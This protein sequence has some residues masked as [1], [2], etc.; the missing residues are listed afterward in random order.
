MSPRLQKLIDRIRAGEIL[1]ADGAWGTQMQKLGLQS[2]DCPEEWNVTH[3]DRLKKIAQDYYH[4]GADFCLT[5][6]FGGTRYR[7]MRHGFADKVDEFN[8]AGFLIVKDVADALDRSVCASVGPTGE[9][10]EPEGMLSRK[11]MRDAFREQMSALKNAGAEW[12]CIETMYVVPEAVEA[13]KAAVELGLYCA[14]CMTFD[15]DGRGG[16]QT[17]FGTGVEEAIHAVDTAGADIVGT[18]CGNGIADMVRIARLIRPATR[19][20]LMVKSNA[21]LPRQVDGHFVY[22]ET[23]G[24]M[25]QKISELRDIGVAIVGGCCGTTPAHIT[26]FRAALDAFKK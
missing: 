9:F 14:A 11:E 2:G 22:D 25:A 3:P 18:N 19:K 20:P 1:L 7:L 15:S 24:M 23:P 13:V 26:A 4:A 6:T 8:R 16:F 10:I 5:N 21:G 12:V 17:L